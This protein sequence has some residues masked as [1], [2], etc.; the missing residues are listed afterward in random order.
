MVSTTLSKLGLKFNCIIETVVS[1]YG[2]DGR[3]T[4]APMGVIFIG[5]DRAILKPFK[6]SQTYQ[7]I[8][9][10]RQFT[11]NLTADPE[12]FYKTALKG[13]LTPERLPKQWFQKS[14]TVDAPILRGADASL[15]ATV[16]EFTTLSSGRAKVLCKVVGIQILRT[17]P[18][19]YCRALLAVIESIIHATRIVEYVGQGKKAQAMALFNQLRYYQK[20]AIKVAPN[21]RYVEIM[22]SILTGLRQHLRP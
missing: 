2:S 8:K 18:R 12:I 1:T 15:E 20:L 10:R 19:Y 4:A 22:N 17:N 14:N 11:V 3:P 21:S 9:N 5:R 13:V 7:N 6:T 16:K